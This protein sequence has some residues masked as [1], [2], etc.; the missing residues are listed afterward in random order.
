MVK[1]GDSGRASDARVADIDRNGNRLMPF[2]VFFSPSPSSTC[3][4]LSQH[5][6]EIKNKLSTDSPCFGPL[7]VGWSK[8]IIVKIVHISEDDHE[9]FGE[10][11]VAGRAS[12]MSSS[13]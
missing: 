6:K 11:R 4:S 13:L 9:H 5:E 8:E 3:S 2:R 1:Y 10:E 7:S 12:L